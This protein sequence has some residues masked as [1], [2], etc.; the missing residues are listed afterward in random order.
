MRVGDY[1]EQD[2][3]PGHVRLVRR[4]LGSMR[5]ARR[6]TGTW[7]ALVVMGAA[8][9]A[10]Q[11]A[12]PASATE[13]PSPEQPGLRQHPDGERGLDARTRWRAAAASSAAW[14]GA[15]VLAAGA[16]QEEEEEDD[17]EDS[18][19]IR[20]FSLP[21][22]EYVPADSVCV[23]QVRVWGTR[24][25]LNLPGP[26]AV[27]GS[28][29]TGRDGLATLYTIDL[30][31]G[32]ATAVG[33]IGFERVGAMDFHP[34]T[35]VLYALGERA[36][37]S[38][39][40]VLITIDTATGEGTEVGPTLIGD[41]SPGHD[42]SFRSDGVLFAMLDDGQDLYTVDTTTGEATFVASTAFHDAGNAIAFS[43]DDDLLFA[44][45]AGGSEGTL[46]T[47][48]T[49]DGANTEVAPLLFPAPG[50]DQPR[51][52]AMDV[53]P[54][55]GTLYASVNDRPYGGGTRENYFGTVDVATG[56]VTIIGATVDGLDAIAFSVAA[57]DGSGASAANGPSDSASAVPLHVKEPEPAPRSI[58]RPARPSDLL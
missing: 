8:V 26:C 2:P 34:A 32:V 58:R 14:A 25:V 57:S 44:T 47:L 48:D 43:Q 19:S 13:G 28:A 15:N 7:V 37:G 27:Y 1:V 55:T 12:V 39:E 17:G 52:N 33:P 41:D 16:D 10:G 45:N 50:D 22:W 23:R 38:D 4:T 51:I 30:R 21:T 5:F 24:W 9:A 20:G 54:E 3:A 36:D 40:A 49:A 18:G 46:H 56:I 6:H 53:D 35:G 42:I 29:Y 31:N 11:A